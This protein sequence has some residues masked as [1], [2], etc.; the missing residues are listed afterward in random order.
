MSEYRKMSDSHP[1]KKFNAFME[2]EVPSPCL[3]QLMTGRH[4]SAEEGTSIGGTGKILAI[5]E[6]GS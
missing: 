2:C 4:P 3:Q 1:V 6:A 5:P